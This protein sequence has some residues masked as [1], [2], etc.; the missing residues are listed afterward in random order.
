MRDRII[1]VFNKCGIMLSN[2]E[3]YINYEFVDSLMFVSMV[4]EIEKEFAIRIPDDFLLI[5]RLQCVTSIEILIKDQFK[6]NEKELRIAIIG[7]GLC[8]PHPGIKG[9]KPQG[10]SILNKKIIDGF[11]DNIGHGTAIYGIKK[12]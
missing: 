1:E 7:S 11:E 3:E 8:Y 6:K 2:D 9:S 12:I 10:I 5:E 4:V